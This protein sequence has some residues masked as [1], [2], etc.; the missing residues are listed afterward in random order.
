MLKPA[1]LPHYHFLGFFSTT[2]NAQLT[3][4][5]TDSQS[6]SNT[7]YRGERGGERER[8]NVKDVCR[9]FGMPLLGSSENSLPWHRL[10][11]SRAKSKLKKKSWKKSK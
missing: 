10:P 5:A 2:F 8:L 3:C 11:P 9:G 1:G 6:F 7:D 4:S